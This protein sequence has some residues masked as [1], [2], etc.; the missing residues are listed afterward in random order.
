M[1][2]WVIVEINIHW[3]EWI[4]LGVFVRIIRRC[5]DSPVLNGGGVPSYG[6]FQGGEGKPFWGQIVPL[7]ENP[8]YS[9]TGT[10]TVFSLTVGTGRGLRKY[11]CSGNI[12]EFPAI[13]Q[14]KMK[15]KEP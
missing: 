6:E 1:F 7:P 2:G 8:Q 4:K 13:P 15:C 11:M 5:Y 14:N 12:G 9:G 10:R 3:M